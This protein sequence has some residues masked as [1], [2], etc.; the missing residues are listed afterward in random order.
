[1]IDIE[2][3]NKKLPFGMMEEVKN[4]RTSIEFAGDNIKSVLFTS[5]MT[6]EG[7]STITIEIAKSYAELNKKVVLVDTDLRKS[8]LMMKIDSGKMEYGLTHYLSG[9]C[10]IDDIIYHDTKEGYENLY[11][12]PTGP[13]TKAPTELLSTEKLGVL[14]DY[15][16]KEYDMVIIDTPPV[17][18]VIDAAI[19]APHT[20]GAV[21]VIESGKVNYKLVQ[22]AIEKFE[23]S[24][25]KVLGVALN[26][27]DKSRNNYGYYKYSK[28][29]TDTN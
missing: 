27:V 7:K 10:E 19:I 3:E 12:V 29:Y 13:A 5:T 22:K 24:G 21:F 14:L 6:N 20:D 11:I 15:L 1:M 4:L 9:Q 25:C 16:K 23:V 26:K 28:E 2:L 17:G 18:T 8:I